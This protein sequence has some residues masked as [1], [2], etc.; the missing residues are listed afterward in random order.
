MNIALGIIFGLVVTVVS[1]ALG[2]FMIPT[3]V[4]YI[5]GRR[6]L[7]VRARKLN[8]IG[9]LSNMGLWFACIWGWV[10]RSALIYVV[11]FGVLAVLAANG[12]G[13]AGGKLLALV[14]V[15]WV[16]SWLF[17]MDTP[18]WPLREG[19]R[20]TRVA[21]KE[22]YDQIAEEFRTNTC[23]Q[24]LLLKSMSLAGGDKDKAVALYTTERAAIL[25]KDKAGQ[26][27]KPVP[28]S[29]GTLLTTAL[30][31]IGIV[32]VGCWFFLKPP[33]TM[34]A[35]PSS[36]L[37]TPPV[38]SSDGAAS[39]A[40]APTATDLYN[41]G[42]KYENGAGVA[43]DDVQAMQW[44]QKAAATGSTAA[45]IHIG[46]FYA[47]GRGGVATDSNQEWAWYNKAAAAGDPQGMTEI[48]VIYQNRAHDY[49]QALQWYQKAAA[50]GNADSMYCLGE[51][52]E[53]GYGVDK[54]EQ[55]AVE[56]FQKGAAL[57]DRD[58]KD[59]LPA[60]MYRLGLSYETGTGLR[61]D[62]S[63]AMEWFQK[64]AT[65]GN[66]DAM[67]GIGGLY[68]NGWGVPQDY[69]QAIQWMNTAANSGNT[70][71]MYNIGFAYEH[72]IGVSIS[73]GDA[74]AW[75]RQAASKGNGDAIKALK[76]LGQPQ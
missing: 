6:W 29:S 17:N 18:V 21:S 8:E 27:Q 20:T 40:A 12:D 71:A 60:A 26:E 30:V 24:G 23:D 66:S 36:A 42:L 15:G 37:S 34:S 4:I 33:T 52:Y 2:P 72:G 28:D 16:M 49:A 47:V 22:V 38:N 14:L 53:N 45:M 56:W 44:Y 41:T 35:S 73:A 65:A 7:T 51:L 54:N 59:V 48:G 55:T 58:C 62:Y 75:Y 67:V 1:L 25:T 69:S 74:A 57:E 32:A 9:R 5:L 39:Q 19:P 70:S 61:T 43:Q 11:P 76:R 13:I 31:I 3:I 10:W 63:Q 46:R 68:M 64:A 50:A